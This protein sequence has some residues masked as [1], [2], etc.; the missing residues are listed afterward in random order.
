MK[1]AREAASGWERVL[2]RYFA[3]SGIPL[4]WD[5]ETRRF[6]GVAGHVF[7]RLNPAK[8]EAVWANIPKY[9]RKY[10]SSDHNSDGKPAIIFVTNRTYG[11]SV[12]DSLVV[13]RLGTFANIFKPF[14]HSDKER[15]IE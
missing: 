13:M 12:E 6:H 1:A 10:E 2:T 5:Y 8:E 11:D 3:A 4:R 15:W 14:V 9:V 7:A